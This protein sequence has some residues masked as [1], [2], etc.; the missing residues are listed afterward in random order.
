MPVQ[1]NRPLL[2][3]ALDRPLDGPA[4][5]VAAPETLT[6]PEW[7]RITKAFGTP[8]VDRYATREAGTIAHER[9]ADDGL[10]LM[11]DDDLIEV[12]DTCGRSLSDLAGE[13]RSWSRIFGIARRHSSATGRA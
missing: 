1:R 9:E 11:M 5:V 12:V 3:V 10:H 4:G 6:P 8:V 2:T 13:G 7:W